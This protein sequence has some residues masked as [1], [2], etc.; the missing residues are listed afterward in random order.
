MLSASRRYTVDE[1]VSMMEENEIEVDSIFIEPPNAHSL[2]DEDSDEEAGYDVNRLCGNQLRVV[3]ETNAINDICDEEPQPEE[4]MTCSEVKA[5]INSMKFMKNK[6]ILNRI[7]IFPNA[8]YRRYENFSPAELFELFFDDYL[9]DLIVVESNRYMKSKNMGAPDINLDEMK[10]FFGILLLSGY[11]HVP[12]RKMYW[13]GNSDVKNEAVQKAMRRDR[14]DQIMSN[15]HFADNDKLDPN[16]KLFKLRPVLRHLSAN[17]RQQ[18]AHVPEQFLCYDESMIRYFGSHYMK[19]FIRGKPL[20]FGYKVWCLNNAAGYCVDFKIYQGKDGEIHDSY[21]TK[22]GKC[23]S[24]LIHFIDNFST[25]I[26]DLNF[27]FFFDNLFTSCSL[28]CELASR[29]YGG[30][31]TVREAR[32][33]ATAK[34]V[35]ST[36]KSFSVQPR[37]ATEFVSEAQNNLLFGV[38]MDNKCVNFASNTVPVYP[39]GTC[40]RFSRAERC[41]KQVQIPNVLKTYNKY[42]GGTDLMDQNIGN[43]RVHIR[44]KKWYFPIFT[45]LIDCA[46]Q[47]AWVL[48]KKS[49]HDLPQLQFRRMVAM[50]YL[51]KY[52]SEPKGA[53]RPSNT[54]V[55]SIGGEIRFDGSGHLVQNSVTRKRCRN[56]CGSIVRTECAKC[57]AGLCIPCFQSYHQRK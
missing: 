55:G 48:K 24:P 47:N 31:G 22:V 50:T 46:L 37:G 13:E 6:D 45:W 17:F 12:S 27:Q 54:R 9:F 29:H 56:S 2:S 53:G 10:C 15:L 43:Y 7:A 28:L 8:D 39:L 36:K 57:K 1:V 4:G 49:G 32:L 25:E 20:R 16:D 38:W 19:Q 51:S 5:M 34:K 42:M 23:A 11:S 26:K 41:R 35:L 3:A 14:F 18:F 33:P 21:N 44:G 52:G 30:T 40:S